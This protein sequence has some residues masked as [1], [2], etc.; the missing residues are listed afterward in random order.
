MRH[1]DKLFRWGFA[2]AGSVMIGLWGDSVM[3]GIGVYFCLVGTG[4][5]N[6]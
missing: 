6:D 2:I 3:L 5:W 1:L 4:A